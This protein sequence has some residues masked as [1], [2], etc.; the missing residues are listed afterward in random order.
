M[1]KHPAALTSPSKYQ[2]ME[3]SQAGQYTAPMQTAQKE[4]PFDTVAS[5]PPPACQCPTLM[6]SEQ[7]GLQLDT[8]QRWQPATPATLEPYNPDHG[9]VG[10][11][12]VT[13]NVHKPSA[14]DNLGGRLSRSDEMPPDGQNDGPFPFAYSMVR[15]TSGGQMQ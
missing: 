3:A 5:R 7:N 14:A 15:P 13:A 6:P 9:I 11:A 8:T 2:R 12:V 4:L 10:T 1:G